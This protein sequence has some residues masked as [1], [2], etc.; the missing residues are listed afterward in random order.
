MTPPNPHVA[1]RMVALAIANYNSRRWQRPSSCPGS[2][3]DFQWHHARTLPRILLRIRVCLQAYCKSKLSPASA[4]GLRCFWHEQ[5]SQ[6][7]DHRR[8]PTRP[9]EMLPTPP[10]TTIAAIFSAQLIQRTCR[11]SNEARQ[12]PLRQRGVHVTKV[13]STWVSR[14]RP[15]PG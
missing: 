14:P 11:L 12:Y 2:C 8:L 6:P 4:A 13:S 9:L 7:Q 1:N 15:R 5:R 3:H 10:A